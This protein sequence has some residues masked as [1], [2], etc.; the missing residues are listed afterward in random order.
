MNWVLCAKAAL[1]HALQNHICCIYVGKLV[2]QVWSQHA[3]HMYLA[4]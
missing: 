3:Y 2:V 1:L 4:I